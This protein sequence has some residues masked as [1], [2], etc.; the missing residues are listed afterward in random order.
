MES[1]LSNRKAKEIVGQCLADPHY[2]YL[3]TITTKV[4]HSKEFCLLTKAVIG[5]LCG[6]SLNFNKEDT[7]GQ[8]R[9]PN[10]S[11]IIAKEQSV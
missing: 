2:T 5:S 3:F 6:F 10:G 7:F 1:R 4:S 11:K 9:F 8:I